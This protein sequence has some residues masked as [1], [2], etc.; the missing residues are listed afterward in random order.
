MKK[1]ILA[2][3]LA[4]LAMFSLAGFYTSVLARDFISEHVESALLR[5]PPNLLLVFAGYFVLSLLMT[6][7]Y[8]RVV[9]VEKSPAWAGLRFGAVAGICWLVPSSLVLFGIYK[10]PYAALPMD[11]GWALIEQ[12]IGGLIIGYILGPTSGRKGASRLMV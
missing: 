1:T 7:I 3:V 2:I 12:G 8:A 4:S 11:F 9:N 6:V 10:F 5:T